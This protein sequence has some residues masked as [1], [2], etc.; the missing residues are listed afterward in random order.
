MNASVTT[1]AHM[2]MQIHTHTHKLRIVEVFSDSL[3][4][5][6]T[7]TSS[8]QHGFKEQCLGGMVTMAGSHP[9]TA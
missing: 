8:M 4:V 1:L 2:H 7:N 3:A 9:F 6:L 5:L